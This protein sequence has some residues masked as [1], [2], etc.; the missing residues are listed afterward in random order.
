M[1]G[2]PHGGSPET[3]A[4]LVALSGGIGGA[5]L[6]LGLAQ[7]LGE[8]LTVIVNT[9]DDF[10][11]L[12]LHISPDVDT[13]VYTLAGLVNPDPGWGRGNETWTFM[14]V[15]AGLG[16]PTWFKLGDGDL[17]MHVE[18]TRRLRA[19]EAL[20][21][22]CMHVTARLGVSA[23]ILPMSDD[24]VRTVLETDAGT[25]GFQDYFVREQ[26][27]PAVRSIR[28]EGAETARP[29]QKVRRALSAPKLA[30]VI[31]CPSN[32]WLSIDPILA[33]PG[34]RAAVRD[35]GVPVIA[36]SPLIGGKAV[37]GPAAKIMHELEL[38]PDSATIAQ[39]YA[40]LLDGLLI[41]AQDKA[42]AD[43]IALPTRVT[44]TFMQTLEDKI[45]LARECV[46]FCKRLAGAKARKDG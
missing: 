46:L 20:T 40:G 15:L 38:R 31:I 33:V 3:G 27:R 37:K 36:V 5:K 29:T 32:P 6:A 16:G 39:H 7:L 14:Q 26:C 19:G 8:A 43:R 10:E 21:D 28:F 25:L 22:I 17:A 18:R 24:P 35:A 45:A 30:G 13:A 44:N 1:S 12:G 4:K 41:D 42:L 23:R 2:A 34:M 11:H 9:G